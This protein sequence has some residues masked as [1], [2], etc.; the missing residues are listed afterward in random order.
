MHAVRTAILALWA[1]SLIY[2][3]LSAYCLS[4]FFG[5][6][7][8]RAAARK[9]GFSHPVT[10][11][12]PMKGADPDSRG[13]VLRF[14]RQDYPEYQVI[15]GV[16]D[17]AD[18][19]AALVRECIAQCPGADAELAVTGAS[20]AANGK[21]GNLLGMYASARHDIII[22]ADAD[23]RV[24]PDYMRAVAAEFGGEDIGL[25][26]CP[27]RAVSPDGIG[28]ALEALTINTELMPSVAV[29]QRLEGLSFALGATMAVRREALEAIGGFSVLADY[30]A[31]DYQLG[32]K[33]REKGYA[34]RLSGH[35]VDSVQGR[36]SVRGYLAHQL[37]WGRTYRACRPGGYFMTVITRGTPFALLYLFA[38]GFAP[39]GWAVL[40]AELLLRYSQAVFIEARY[41]KAP[42]VMKY[43]W[44]L[45]LRDV[46]GFMLWAWSFAGSRVSWRGEKFVIGPDGKMKRAGG[47]V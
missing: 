12:V 7:R 44:L 11:L 17:P 38:A 15:F 37:R 45:P 19:A 29:A 33:V 41:V 2:Y 32:A 10:L 3:V 9:G 46:L 30:L 24:G 5:K 21:V 4:S 26:T 8:R 14:L 23:I 34:L 27:Y 6:A 28:A 18:P 13:N 16:A 25:V 35:V 22:I 40:A 36:V 42:G 39:A 47:A 31:D 1:A 43:V 20:G